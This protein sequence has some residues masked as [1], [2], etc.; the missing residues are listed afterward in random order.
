MAVDSI[1]PIGGA[2]AAQ[3][4]LY[5]FADAVDWRQPHTIAELFTE[6]GVFRLGAPE[7][8]G[9]PAILAFYETRLA[10]PRRI[11]RHLWS[12]VERTAANEDEVSLRA[13]LTNYI[14]EPRVSETE[15]QM[16][17]GN[18]RAL[19]RRGHDGRWRFAEHVYERLYAMNLPLA[20][21]FVPAFPQDAMN[22]RP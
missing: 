13:V 12:N 6:D 19:C 7:L 10:D 5:R 8:R 11:A 9:R 1:A 15:V 20:P 21:G 14:F 17:V 4:V 16:W 3:L 2:E 18:L 22:D